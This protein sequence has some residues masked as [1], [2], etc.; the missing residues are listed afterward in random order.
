MAKDSTVFVGLDVHKETIVAAYSVGFGEVSSLGN[1]GVRDGDIDRLCTRMQSKASQVVFVYEA[2]PCGYGLQRYLS[3]KGFECRVCAPSLIAKKPGDRVKTDRRD[4]EKLVKALRGEDLSFVHVPDAR[5]EAFRDL[6]RAWGGAKDDL[7]RAK[8]RL[9]SFLLVHGVRY[10]G[11]ADWREA[12]RRWLSKFTF[13]EVWSQLAFEEHRRSIEDRLAQCQRLEQT[14]RDAA[15]AWRFYPVIQS[16]QALRGVQFTVA[17][18][19]LAEAG[20]LSRFDNP[21]QLMKWLGIVPS[22]HSSGPSVR[23]GGIT[24]AGNSTARKLLIEA[25][26][27]YRY[28]AKVSTIIQKRHEG[29]PKPIIDRA[30]DAQLRLCRRFRKLSLEGKHRNVVVTAVARELSGFI[31]DIA[32]RTPVAA[33]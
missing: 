31:W 23:K 8:Q 1:V 25:A 5:D 20:D 21:R 6:V 12:H 9:K 15:P 27:S 33:T 30:W 16:L 17:V 13:P 28:S 19:V 3:R 14:L 18:G 32:R 2:G 24:K 4:A 29:L 10:T 7:K 22:E 11:T 26:W